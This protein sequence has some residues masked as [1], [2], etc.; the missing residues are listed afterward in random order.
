MSQKDKTHRGQKRY[1]NL[2]WWEWQ[3]INECNDRARRAKAKS[4]DE[5]LKTTQLSFLPRDI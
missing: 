1:P 5:K 4:L 3:D 2:K